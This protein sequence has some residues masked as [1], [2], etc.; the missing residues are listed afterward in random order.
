[1]STK[2]NDLPF[3]IVYNEAAGNKES[4]ERMKTVNAVLQAANRQHEF[5]PISNL[6]NIKATALE[7]KK[8]AEQNGGALI[9]AGGDGTISSVIQ[10]VMPTDIPLSVLPFGTFNYF[11]REH[12]IPLDI[13]DAVTSLLTAVIKSVQLGSVNDKP[14]VINASAG[15]YAELLHDREAFKQRFG[16]NRFVAFCAAVATVFKRHQHLKIQ[17][18]SKKNARKVTTTT[19]FIGNNSLQLERIG[20]PEAEALSDGKLAAVMV[21]PA[22]TFTLLKL[23]LQGVMGQL[24]EASDI[25]SFAFSELTI[26]PWFSYIKRRIKLGVDGEMIS[27]NTPL[28]FRPYPHRLQLLVPFDASERKPE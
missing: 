23:L 17:I 25:K 10:T 28:V 8:L 3:Y 5:L 27:L 20:L 19:M 18:E 15:L 1:M 22:G 2:S 26:R 13:E 21:R 12:R 7:A 16:R 11:A 6:R 4:Q 14:F 9:I 24:G